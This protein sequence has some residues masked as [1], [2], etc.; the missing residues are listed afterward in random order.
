MAL[1][2]GASVIIASSSQERV[3]GAVKR[4]SDLG[5]NQSVEGRVCNITAGEAAIKEFFEGLPEFNHLSTMLA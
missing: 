5:T 1:F 2:S 4:L 3:D